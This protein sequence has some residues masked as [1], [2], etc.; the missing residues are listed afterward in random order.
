MSIYI[1]EEAFDSFE[2]GYAASDRGRHDGRHSRDHDVCSSWRPRLGASLRCRRRLRNAGSTGR[3]SR[4]WRVIGFFMLLPFAWLFSMSFRTVKDAYQMPPSF[5]PPRL[6]FDNYRAVLNSSVPFLADLRQ[7]RR[8]RGHRHDRPARHLHAGRLRLRA[9]EF[10]RTRHLVLR[11]AGRAAVS[12]AGH[13]HPDLSRLR[14]GRAAEPT[15]RAGA[16]V[17]DVELRRVPCAA[18]HALPAQGAGGSG[19]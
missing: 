15:D 13:D 6:D 5:F 8:G 12:G 17:S 10:S 3:S 19:V 7:Q 4:S 14:P 16:D 1:V 2:I 18:I 11:H 9:A